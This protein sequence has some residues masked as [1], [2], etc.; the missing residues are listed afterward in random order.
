[1]LGIPFLFTPAPNTTIGLPGIGKVVLNEQLTTTLD[2]GNV[3]FT[4]NMIHVVVSLPNL[5]NIPIGTEVVVSSATSGIQIIP[6]V[7]AVDGIGYGTQIQGS[8]VQSSPTARI[9][10]PCRGT[11]G[12]VNTASVA[13][14]NVL[15]VL[16]SG[17]ITNTV[18]GDVRGLPASSETTS[19]IQGVNLLMGLIRAS[20]IQAQADGSTTDSVNLN[21]SATGRFV[22]LSVLGHPEI[23]DNV[24]NN[25]NVPLLGFGTIY[26]RRIIPDV[27]NI[28]MRMLEVVINQRNVLGIPIG[29]DIIVG[30][31]EASLHPGPP[32]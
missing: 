2:P 24:A 23:N 29:T 5:L 16:S 12:V 8:T 6:G 21:F 13:G 25:T 32:R 15:G 30:S 20:V 7:A 31:A 19:T 14:I 26:L 9:L 11:N 4:V 27:D 3:H 28:E 17:T 22:G 10:L 1:V 18:V